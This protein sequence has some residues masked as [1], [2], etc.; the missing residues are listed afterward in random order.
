MVGV[1]DGVGRVGSREKGREGT[2]LEIAV[3]I[4]MR[5]EE[6]QNSCQGMGKWEVEGS[7]VYLVPGGR[8]NERC[9]GKGLCRNNQVDS[10]ASHW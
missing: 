8:L 9:W 10:G 4:Q 6:D 2:Q 5:D 7:S 1:I 3:I